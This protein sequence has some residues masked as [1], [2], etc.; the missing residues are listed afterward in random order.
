LALL[1]E[2]PVPQFW[3]SGYWYVVPCEEFKPNHYRAI[4]VVPWTGVYGFVG[5][6]PYALIRSPDI[7]LNPPDVAVLA[8]EV[9]TAA[10][11]QGYLPPEFDG[12]PGM[13]IE[14]R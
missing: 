1:P 7:W 3:D 6:V 5:G 12:K 13:R 9:V 2:K 4:A 11:A 10:K 8:E 14:S